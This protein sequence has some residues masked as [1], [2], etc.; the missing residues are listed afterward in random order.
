[1]KAYQYY[2]CKIAK[3]HFIFCRKCRKHKNTQDWMRV[4]HDTSKGIKNIDIMYKAIRADHVQVN[5]IRVK[6][7]TKSQQRFRIA[8]I[9]ELSQTDDEQESHERESHGEVDVNPITVNR[10]HSY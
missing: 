1:M 10:T 8:E 6:T 4:N 7:S 2:L 3:T 9:E 5:S